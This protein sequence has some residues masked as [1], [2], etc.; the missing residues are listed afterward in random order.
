M[1]KQLLDHPGVDEVCEL[2]SKFG[3]MA[4]H[5]GNVEENTDVIAQAAAQQSGSSYYGAHQPPGMRHHI[6]SH[7][8]SPTDSPV[9]LPRT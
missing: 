5:G 1:F 6:P 4:F 8:I 9:T 7:L 2:R 3:F